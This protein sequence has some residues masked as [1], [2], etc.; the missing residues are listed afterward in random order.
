MNNDDIVRIRNVGD[1]VWSDRFNNQNFVVGPDKEIVVPWAAAKLWLGDP[2]LR[3]KQDGRKER[4]EEQTRLM[5]R[6]GAASRSFDEWD[7]YKPH[8]EVYD[9]DNQRIFML[10]DQ[11]NESPSHQWTTAD[12]TLAIQQK[13]D[14]MTRQLAQMQAQRANLEPPDEDITEDTPSKIPT[15]RVRVPD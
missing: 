3:D 4:R 5:V 15:S 2:D 10:A 7:N 6:Y 13:I 12:E 1:S 11:F 9:F 14:S 8:I